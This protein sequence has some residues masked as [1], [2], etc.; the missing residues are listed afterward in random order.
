M[1]LSEIEEAFLLI[2]RQIL[3]LYMLFITKVNI[4]ELYVWITL[5][6]TLKE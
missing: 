5:V 3:G 6:K 4:L 1:R 2:K